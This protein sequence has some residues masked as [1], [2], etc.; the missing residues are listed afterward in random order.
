VNA[1]C[2]SV[3][4]L[5]SPEQHTQL[6][7]FRIV[8]WRQEFSIVLGGDTTDLLEHCL[9]RR[10]EMERA[11]PTILEVASSL[12]ETLALQLVDP[13]DNP[14]GLSP[15]VV[16]EHL[17][18]LTRCERNRSQDASLGRRETDRDHPLGELLS[19]ECAKLRQHKG[20][21][22][23]RAAWGSGKTPDLTGETSDAAAFVRARG[24]RHGTILA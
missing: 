21:A 7:A 1:W 4:A 5:E 13:N 18:T 16:G 14:A 10:G 11:R 6:S 9:P 20:G 22:D 24:Q 3:V 19:C 12:H 2:K 17:L 8:E 15:Q 23:R